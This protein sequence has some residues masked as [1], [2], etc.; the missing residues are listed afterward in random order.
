MS[1]AVE[2]DRDELRNILARFFYKKTKDYPRNFRLGVNVLKDGIPWISF[3]FELPDP[4][5]FPEFYENFPKVV[6]ELPEGE[7]EIPRLKIRFYG[8]NGRYD[9][10]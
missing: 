3:R 1:S 5:E 2:L 9:R 8:Y 4:D 7:Y 6:E 10:T